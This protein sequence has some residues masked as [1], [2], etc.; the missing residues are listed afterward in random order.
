MKKIYL[1]G[2]IK[3]LT[4]NQDEDGKGYSFINFEVNDECITVLPVLDYIPEYMIP[5]WMLNKEE[6]EINIKVR[7]RWDKYYCYEGEFWRS[8]RNV[9]I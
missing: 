4:L 8:T 9:K 3:N 7:I 6:I 1:K 2:V 5:K